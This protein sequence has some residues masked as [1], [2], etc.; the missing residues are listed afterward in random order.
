MVLIFYLFI[1]LFCHELVKSI[2]G[3]LLNIFFC[4]LWNIVGRLYCSF[5]GAYLLYLRMCGYLS[6]ACTNCNGQRR[7]K[8]VCLSNLSFL[9]LHLVFGSFR[10]L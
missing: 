8:Q 3:I 5:Y 2:L 1:Y 4:V 10:R 7:K 6:D 9:W